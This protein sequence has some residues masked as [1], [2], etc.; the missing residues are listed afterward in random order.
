[1]AGRLASGQL[2]DRTVK[3]AD[4]GPVALSS[5]KEDVVDLTNEAVDLA[6]VL[7][8]SGKSDSPSQ[9]PSPVAVE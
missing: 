1:M 7:Q 8:A 2:L 6:V 3:T 5:M 4:H 9:L